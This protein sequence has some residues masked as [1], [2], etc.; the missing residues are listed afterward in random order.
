MFPLRDYVP[1]LHHPIAVWGII[2]V[3]VLFFLY[4]MGLD[5]VELNRLFHVLGVVPARY[6]QPEWAQWMGY[7][8]G[9][10][11]AFL[12]HMFLHSGFFHFVLNMWI[13]WVFADNVE[14][15]MGPGRFIVFYVL[16]GLG[17][18]G[19]HL[20]FHAHSE[21][22][23]VGASG[24]IAGVMGA[25]LLLYPHAR[26][27]TLIPIF[28]IPYFLDL[29]AVL[30]LG[31]WF[32]MQVLSGVLAGLEGGSGAGVAWWAHAGGFV[33]GMVLIPF[34]RVPSRC[35]YCHTRTRGGRGGGDSFR[36]D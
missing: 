6:F 21:V 26:V 1:R 3:N 15:V 33:M 24:A 31:L 5:Q 17:A 4:A 22:P 19:A 14:D 9:G 12:A 18:L 29:P 36:F 16:C 8:R 25:Y 28:F 20:L 11:V 27:L 23:V 13:L 32:A 35:Y 34:F 2:G 30:F 10:S 7:P